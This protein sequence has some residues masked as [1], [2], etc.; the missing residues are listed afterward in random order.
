[1][2]GAQ[3]AR[4]LGV[5]RQ[6]IS[7]A[8]K[9]GRIRKEPNGKFDP[10][11][12]RAM[13]DANRKQAPATR[14]PSQPSATSGLAATNAARAKLKLEREQMEFDAYKGTL[15]PRAEA[16]AFAAEIASAL[17]SFCSSLP[18]RVAQPI[19]SETGGDARA[20]RRI[21]EAEVETLQ[22]ELAKRF[23]KQEKP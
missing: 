16:E 8:A 18:G 20:I 22:A 17:Q 15:I 4:L 7:K 23:R 13:W 9:Q 2:N 10:D 19:A 12:A 14:A 5:S 1:M 11:V 21:V 3:L 6:A